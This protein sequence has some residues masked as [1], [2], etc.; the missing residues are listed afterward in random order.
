MTRTIR[1]DEAIEKCYKVVMATC[2]PETTE[3]CAAWLETLRI[4]KSL[5]FER[6]AFEDIKEKQ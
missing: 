2:D 3:Q 4:L 6:V 1:T 5:G